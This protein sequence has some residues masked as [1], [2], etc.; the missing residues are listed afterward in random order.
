VIDFN[1]IESPIS[2]TSDYILSKVSEEQIYYYYF[3]RFEL[4]KVYPSKFRRDSNPSTGFYISK[5]GKIIYN[6]L[7]TGEKVNCFSFV[8]KLY[9]ISYKDALN[10]IA[11][12]F[13]II[14]SKEVKPIA[15]KI[16]NQ[17]ISFDREAKKDTIIQV[18][19][20]KWQAV[21][22]EYWKQY[23]VDIADLKAQEV[24]PV[25][26]LFVN[27]CELKVDELCFAYI[28][29]E[30]INA[31]KEYRTY[32]KVYQP[33]N[34]T[35]KWLSNV[36]ITVPFGLDTLKYGTDHVVVGKAQKDRL[37]LLKLFQSVIGTQN[38]SEAALQESL[39]KHLCFHY[40]QRTIIWDADET[41]VENCKKFNSRGFGY[42]NTPKHMLEHG[43]KDISDYVKEFGLSQL[44]RLL[45]AKNIL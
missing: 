36:P 19:P 28:V 10:R 26:K 12:D 14:K 24:Y 17:S 20:D 38:E 18:V 27:K 42:F 3:G 22:I 40:P 13:G 37:I 21:H 39:V 44:E 29:K 4:G 2:L 11:L 30:K 16:L 25:K 15:Q 6:D 32:I 41:G 43:I 9:N 8:A 5:S 7:K 23:E 31:T 33:Y 35:M 34:K 45:K 1:Q